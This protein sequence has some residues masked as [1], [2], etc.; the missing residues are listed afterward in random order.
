M[1][2]ISKQDFFEL[3]PIKIDEKY[4]EFLTEEDSKELEKVFNDESVD[5]QDY[6]EKFYD[7]VYKRVRELGLVS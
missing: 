1:T 7:M 3:G 4:G 6:I 5:D 2:K